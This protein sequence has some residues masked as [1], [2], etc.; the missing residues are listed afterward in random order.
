MS[1]PSLGRRHTKRAA[2]LLFALKAP[3]PANDN[4]ATTYNRE[5]PS[6]ATHSH[7]LHTAEYGMDTSRPRKAARDC[8]SLGWRSRSLAVTKKLTAVSPRD[9]C[10]RENTVSQCLMACCAT[11]H[12]STHQGA[13]GGTLLE[14]APEAARDPPKMPVQC[15]GNNQSIAHGSWLKRESGC[16][17]R[18]KAPGRREGGGGWP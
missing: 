5:A 7:S 18:R 16:G 14:A 1:P 3:I 6:R 15:T 8:H 11:S 9:C 12:P 13:R 2:S 17:P 4:T 10:S